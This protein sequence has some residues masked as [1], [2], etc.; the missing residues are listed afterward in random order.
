MRIPDLQQPPFDT[1]MLGVVK[2]A[3]DHYG[4]Q[5][6]TPA[7]FALS[8]HAFVINIHEELCPSS[9]YCWRYDGFF[10]LLRNLGLDMKPLA[11]LPPDA[12]VGAKARVEAMLREALDAGT[13]CSLLHLDNQLLL[14]YDA[15]GFT[16]AQPWGGAVDSTPARLAFGSWQECQAGPPLTFF[17]LS[18]CEPPVGDPVGAALDLA[19]DVWRAPERLAEPRYGVGSAAY[20][21]WLAAIDAGHGG[22]HGAWWNAVVWAECRERA[23]DYFQD[24]A[25]AE[26]P[27]TGALDQEQARWF[28]RQYRAIAKLLYRASDK[29]AAIADKRRF[30]AEA[31]DH[32]AAGIE[33]LAEL[34][35]A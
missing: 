23:G 12:D 8:G 15:A 3:L 22:D 13:V 9:P 17:R 4:Q 30:V 5:Q 20:E 1:S 21:N 6:T 34:R 25:A 26:F 16:L 33:R 14:G 35:G 18:P 31:R 27:A 7:A 29:T 2:G 11:T 19:L 32:E 24:L 28:A 10:K